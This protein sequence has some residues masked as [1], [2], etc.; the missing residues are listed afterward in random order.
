M[1]M[2]MATSSS[3]SL[4]S[5]S[6]EKYWRLM[7]TCAMCMCRAPRTREG[8]CG[9]VVVHAVVMVVVWVVVMVVVVNVS[10]SCRQKRESDICWS[11]DSD[12]R[13]SSQLEWSQQ[14]TPLYQ[15]QKLREVI[16]DCEP[17]GCRGTT[18]VNRFESRR[19]RVRTA[20]QQPSNNHAHPP[21][22]CVRICAFVDAGPDGDALSCRHTR[23]KCRHTC[24]CHGVVGQQLDRA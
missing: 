9:C 20:I 22:L 15:P 14:P 6:A 12:A 17:L 3:T 2:C 24:G 11:E 8:V 1:M 18:E 21:H 4:A 19:Q 13:V 16:I 5:A 10:V 7:L 23:R